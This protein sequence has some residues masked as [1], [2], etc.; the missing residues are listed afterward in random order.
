[1]DRRQAMLMPA[2]GLAA[3][4]PHGGE[5]PK[6]LLPGNYRVKQ[7]IVLRDDE[8]IAEAIDR[9]VAE[10]IVVFLPSSGQVEL[11]LHVDVP[12]AS[13]AEVDRVAQLVTDRQNELTLYR[14]ILPKRRTA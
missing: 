11:A 6:R 7:E 8:S 3:T 5:L 4:V 12:N 2:L 9:G 1:M 10:G 14:R 13:D